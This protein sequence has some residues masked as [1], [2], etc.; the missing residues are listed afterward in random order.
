MYIKW[1]SIFITD[2]FVLH[3]IIYTFVYKTNKDA[4]VLGTENNP[5]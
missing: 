3:Q 1:N 5:L 2:F 4:Q